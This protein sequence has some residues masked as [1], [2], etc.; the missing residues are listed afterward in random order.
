VP[1]TVEDLARTALVRILP[2]N[3]YR[4]AAQTDS[5][6]QSFASNTAR[7][8]YRQQGSTPSFLLFSGPGQNPQAAAMAAATWAEAN[9]RPN[10]IQRKV[11][12]GVVVVLVAPGN[13]LMPAGPV[14]GA[15]V[16]SAVWTVDSAAGQVEAPGKPP[17]S[18][19]ASEL[20]HATRA[21]M[22]G[23]PAPSLGELDLAE[24]GVMQLRTVAMPRAV[25]GLLGIFLLYFA[26]RYGLG[27]LF[28]LMLLPGVLSAGGS[29]APGVLLAIA[30]LVVNVLLLLGILLG[31]GIFLNFRSM[32]VRVPGF[33][34]SAP[35]RRNVTW[36]GYVAVMIGL[37]IALD[38]VIP[39]AERQSVVNAG[40]SQY[41]HVLA[42]VSD[43]G[44]G[45]YV[46]IGGDLTVDLS[47][48]PSSEWS[49]IQ[50]KTSNP[51]VLSLDAPPNASGPPIARF[52]ARES[53]VSRIDATSSDGSYTFQ[54][55]V[56]VGPGPP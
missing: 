47:G 14:A 50:F 38:V 16:P 49:G 5:R 51:S 3:R 56:D 11:R 30:T 28:S 40:Q 25:G 27:G 46:V 6:F 26:F 53:G 36:G 43:D 44:G 1:F 42:T 21:L 15:V 33:S 32:A 19:S 54:L 12:P 45:S 41:T 29:T 34:S 35:T 52:T 37:A 10:A 9:W 20:R 55:R 23:E 2:R 17:G 31:A 8:A 4:L 24:K 39:A 48:W 7:I 18:P 22:R 13:Q